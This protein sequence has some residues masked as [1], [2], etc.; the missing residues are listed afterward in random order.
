MK[1]ALILLGAALLVVAVLA[2]ARGVFLEGMRGAGS[3][4]VRLLPMLV[5]AFLLAG[6]TEAILPRGF[7][8]RWL[9]EDSGVRGYLLAWAAGALTPAGGVVGLPLA[10]SLLSAGAGAGVL[11]TYLTSL[12]V[13]PIIRL[14]MELGIYGARLALLRIMSS[15]ILPPLAGLL[16][17][18]MVRVTRVL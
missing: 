8:E 4:F 9:S 1:G 10:A 2:V 15:L 17:Q 12:A 5:L 6:L 13:L 14:P 3:S 11:V 18:L 16:A 7:V